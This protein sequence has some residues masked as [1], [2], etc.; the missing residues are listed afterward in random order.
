MDI[1]V[2]GNYNSGS[3]IEGR[4]KVYDNQDGVFTDSGNQ[5]PA[6]LASGSRGGSFT[7][8]DIDGE[9]D[10]DYFIAGQYF[11]PGG[12]G[13][14][15]AQMHVYRNDAEGQN[16]PPSAPSLLTAQVDETDGTVVLWWDS[17]SDDFTP[18]HAL[19]YDL[20]LYR[21]GT[22]ALTPHR[23]PE[24][25]SLSA[26]GEWTLAGLPDGTYTWTLRAVDSA[27]NGGEE[28]ESTFIVGVPSLIFTDGYESGDLSGWST[29][30]Q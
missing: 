24:P 28:A 15:E 30:S 18:P 7:W 21:E 5:L 4:A 13:L 26:V 6:P 16:R 14:V 20:R 12:N 22:P 19:T 17:A 11:V 8:L 23:L 29:A 25:G 27:F 3:Q 9:G 1:L 2:A 10:L